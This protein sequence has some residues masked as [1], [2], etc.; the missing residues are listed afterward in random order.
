DRLSEKFLALTGRRAVRVLFP[1]GS[2]RKSAVIVTDDGDR[3]VITR[4]RH[5]GRAELEAEV[6]GQLKRQGAPV[7]E[8]IARDGKW[9]VQEN[10]GNLRLSEAIDAAAPKQ[11]PVLL[12][13][14][15]ESLIA[16]HQ[17][18]RRAGLVGR[19]VSIGKEPSWLETLANMPVRIGEHLKIPA[20]ALPHQA[21]M[22][23]LVIKQPAF[24]KWD[25]RPGNAALRDDG[26]VGWFDW[27]HCGCRSP[28]DDLAWFLGD[29]WSPDEPETE[30]ILL[31]GYLADF[32]G[33]DSSAAHDY[34]M[35][36]G[37]LH[38]CVRLSLILSRKDGGEW[39]DRDYCLGGDK[40]GVT[41]SEAI[42]VAGRAA[43][44]SAASRLLASL[45]PWF[46]D[47]A[48]RIHEL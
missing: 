44:W 14:A 38:M 28:L 20:P 48:E 43:R 1:G 13:A 24:I 18:G 47:V 33:N 3:L 32:T 8:I 45:S 34:L 11:R 21:I 2:S 25:A 7:P 29:E 39:W 10:L 9:I 46:G 4:R 5:E 26:T 16:L 12:R 35:T 15:V 37:T 19:V 36:F 41:L 23:Q 17:A 27:E 31:D 40:I 6:L 22:A 30:A 42:T